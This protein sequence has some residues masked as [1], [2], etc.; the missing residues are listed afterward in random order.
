MLPWAGYFVGKPREHSIR[1]IRPVVLRL[2]GQKRGFYSENRC[3]G[4]ILRF[5]RRRVRLW[6]SLCST[7][8]GTCVSESELDQICWFLFQFLIAF[9]FV[10]NYDGAFFL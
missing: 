4:G 6:H 5:Q 2:I 3:W 8:P 1:R 9:I 10:P 7:R